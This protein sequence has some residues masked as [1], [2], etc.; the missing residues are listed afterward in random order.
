M[1][2]RMFYFFLILM[3]TIMFVSCQSAENDPP[4]SPVEQTP[5]VADDE[6]MP[7]ATAVLPEASSEKW[8]VI[9]EVI[10]DHL[11][12][13]AYFAN[14]EFGITACNRSASVP[15][16][17]YTNDGGQTWVE[18]GYTN[19]SCPFGVDIVDSDSIWT[20][21]DLNQFFISD[22]FQSWQEIARP[23]GEGC[24]L[25]SFVDNENGWAVA[26]TLKNLWATSDNGESWEEISLPD[27]IET[28]ASISVRTPQDGYLLDFDQML[29]ETHDGGQTWSAQTLAFDNSK[30][31]FMKMGLSSAA[32]RFTDADSG[33]V[34]L[35]TAGGGNSA[36]LALHTEDGGLTWDEYV[37]P[38]ELGS[39]YL[40]H[41]GKY[42]TVNVP[43]KETVLIERQSE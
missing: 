22:G 35:N 43:G 2:Q 27:E 41:D 21:N 30:L 9:K 24:R 10:I 34:I 33:V 17:H 1:F 12:G 31:A 14:S 6:V 3:L 8:T 4:V 18:T 40:S 13:F 29:W 38:A 42:L 26:T 23:A 7:T 16:P 11:P 39:V 25:L 19:I 15:K 5:E 28:I 20:C 37:I 32:I 36:L